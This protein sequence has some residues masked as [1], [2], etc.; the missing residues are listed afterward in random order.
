MAERPAVGR[1]KALLLVLA[2]LVTVGLLITMAVVAFV[3]D[4]PALPPPATIPVGGALRMGVVGAELP[5]DPATSS[6][7]DTGA[8]MLDDL[9]WSRL[10][11][12]DPTTAAP[13]PALAES[14]E[15]QPDQT[16][17][18]FHLRADATF[19]DGSPVTSA[20]VAASLT[21]VAAQGV[22]SLAGGRLSTVKG[23]V[24]AAT[25]GLSGVTTPDPTTVVIEL[26][27]PVADLPVILA[28]PSFG[29]VPAAAAKGERPVLPGPT[30]GPYT[31]VAQTADL[32]TL[33]RSPSVTSDLAHIDTVEVRRYDS[34]DTAAAAFDAG[35]L[36]LVPLPADRATGLVAPGLGVVRTS[37]AAALWW[38]AT[39]TTD[40]SLTSVD[41]RKGLAHAADR[42][43]I[44]SASLPGRRL[45]DGLYPPQLPGGTNGACGS[46]CTLDPA[47]TTAAAAATFPSGVPEILLDTPDTAGPAAASSAFATSLSNAGVPITVRARPFADYRADVLTPDR[48]MFWFGWVGVAPTPEA[49]LPALFLTGAPDNV[50]GFSDPVVDT[51][52]RAARATADPGERA[53]RWAEA[54]R[55][56]LERMPL[57][58]LAQAQN[59]V[60]TSSALQGFV[61][62][63]DGTFAVSQLWLAPDTSTTATTGPVDR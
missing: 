2:G 25:A 33:S 31:V 10:T 1:A 26:T 50:F 15:A 17:F 21:R 42:A 20:D 9:L 38:F 55:L 53:S 43:A 5:V 47:A 16:R 57:V 63:L 61:Q 52:I 11:A 3:D 23:Y 56:V 27:E 13:V 34:D 48:Q 40:L 36:D 18:T 37:P 60:A 32:L 30:S 35:G 4:P 24:D 19:S 51:A 28:A 7:T 12:T 29:V 14:W 49:Y 62:R 41:F 39:D 58:P 59:A 8:A 22:S 46:L 44:V 45:L 6:V 54:E